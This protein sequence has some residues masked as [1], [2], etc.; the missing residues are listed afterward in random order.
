MSSV[1]VTSAVT[2]EIISYE[3]Y[4]VAYLVVTE[5]SA[6]IMM[7]TVFHELPSA[8]HDEMSFTIND[9][10]SSTA[11]ADKAQYG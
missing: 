9:R 10:I 3:L 11:F 5:L 2:M 6:N 1:P 4:V 8:I 7:T